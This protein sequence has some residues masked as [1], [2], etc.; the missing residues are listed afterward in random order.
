MKFLN[1][2]NSY[3]KKPTEKVI[4]KRRY[5]FIIFLLITFFLCSQLV[6][7]KTIERNV[8]EIEKI[9]NIHEVFI[10][11][12]FTRIEVNERIQKD[13]QYFV[14]VY[15]KLIQNKRITEQIIFNALQNEVPVNIAF[16][17]SFVESNWIPEAINIHN[18]NESI[19]V[20]LFQLNSFTFPHLTREEMEDI[21]VNI[22][23]GIKFFKEKL[24]QTG[25]IETALLLYNAGNYNNVG[26]TSI[27]YLQKILDKE[28][29]LDEYFNEEYRQYLINQM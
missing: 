10:I 2:S 17:Q 14:D 7:I 6:A 11:D 5:Q 25:T 24:L 26:R 1:S 19:D 22:F 23:I 4:Q 9:N 20:G 18:S 15:N 16:A 21:D 29:Q 13:L 12:Y 8:I 3:R 27:L 28:R